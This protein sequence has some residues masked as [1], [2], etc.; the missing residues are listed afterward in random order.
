M[1]RVAFAAQTRD[2]LSDFP[3]EVKSMFGHALYM[4]QTGKTHPDAK[5]MRGFP[6]ASVIEVRDDHAGDTYRLVYTA[7]G[8]S[9]ITVLHAFKKKSRRG[10]RTPKQ[11]IDTIRQRLKDVK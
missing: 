1:K 11:I 2:D 10:I 9:A 5:A 7:K 6:G 8:G 4:A 3:A